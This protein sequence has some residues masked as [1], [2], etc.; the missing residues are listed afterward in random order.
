M[1]LADRLRQMV[2]AMPDEGR[3]TLPA[4]VVRGWID[5]EG[6]DPDRPTSAQHTPER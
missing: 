3:I 1:T 6:D 5:K 4:L 2:T